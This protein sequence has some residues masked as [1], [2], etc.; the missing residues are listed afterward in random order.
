[1]NRSKPELIIF[2]LGRVLIDF[3]FKKVIRNLKNHTHL[4]EKQIRRFFETTPLW[5]AFER[6]TVA[7]EDFFIQ[8][9][10]AL[11]LKKLSF[12]T[13]AVF[14]NDI[15]TEMH[16]SVAILKSLKGRYRLALLS[17]IN[18]MHWVHVQKHHA[19]LKWFDHPI[20]SY[21]IGLRKPEK[22]I[23]Q[24]VLELAGNVPADKAMFFDDVQEHIT[25]ARALG[26]EAHQFTSAAQLR[27]DLAHV[28]K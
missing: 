7:P 15:F 14:W 24:K 4:D 20:A 27:R 11:G 3:D 5:D 12:E 25:A 21:A 8:L 23:Y 9:S 10:H 18:P 13:F 22:A 28:L 6:G 26:I 16:E 19:F 1:M 2:D 17:N